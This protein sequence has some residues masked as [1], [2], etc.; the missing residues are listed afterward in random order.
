[1]V[2]YD[3]YT[4]LHYV[5]GNVEVVLDIV[6]RG[7]KTAG[8]DKTI[9]IKIGRDLFL[10]DIREKTYGEII[11]SLLL[12]YPHTIEGDVTLVEQAIRDY[13]KNSIS[14]IL[15]KTSKIFGELVQDIEISP[16]YIYVAKMSSLY[17][18]YQWLKPFYNRTLNHAESLKKIQTLSVE[19]LREL[20]IP[21]RRWV[22]ARSILEKVDKQTTKTLFDKVSRI[23]EVATTIPEIEP[24]IIPATLLA[25]LTIRTLTEKPHPLLR[26]PLLL[27]K[28]RDVKIATTLTP[29]QTQ[30]Y[31]LTGVEQLLRDKQSRKMT[32][33][34]IV[35]SSFILDISGFKPVIVKHYRD[36]TSIK[37]IIARVATLQLPKPILSPRK[38]LLNEFKYNRLLASLGFKTPD[39]VLLDPRRLIAAYTY[40]EGVD[41]IELLKEDR[42]P[43]TY[44][45]LGKLL[46]KLHAHGISLWDANPSNFVYT[47]SGELYLV[48][49]EQ[50]RSPASFDEKVFDI[51]IASY[52]T[53]M[54]EPSEAPKRAKLIAEGYLEEGGDAKTIHSATNYKY[55]TPFIAEAYLLSL[56]K[57]RKALRLVATSRN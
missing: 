13:L 41:L 11:S 23:K 16:M 40:V 57:T 34:G 33:R 14:E 44:R 25:S 43:E 12:A 9:Y 46:A 53:I 2:A 49:L 52:Y 31:K 7:L 15:Q 45:D 50:A 19:A 51:A 48:D 42:A 38:R 36:V 20:D 56:D 54:Y 17:R 4:R 26:D 1:M 5:L 28:T 55:V 6:D 37:W 32:R 47:E 27:V 30:L 3:Y 39:P 35:R 10:K 22:K 29:F 24:S 8:R 21:A 18:V